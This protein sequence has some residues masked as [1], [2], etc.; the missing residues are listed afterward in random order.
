MYA[1]ILDS[2]MSCAFILLYDEV[3]ICLLVHSDFDTTLRP[4]GSSRYRKAALVI[5]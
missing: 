3:D 4:R 1:L 2:G 5:Q